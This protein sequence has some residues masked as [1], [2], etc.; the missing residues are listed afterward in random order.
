MMPV[1]VAI[2]GWREQECSLLN[3]NAIQ[4]RHFINS[5]KWECCKTGYVSNAGGLTRYQMKRCI[6]TFLRKR[7][8]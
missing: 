7:I 2:F 3:N 6:D 4:I 5:Q 8:F 1:W